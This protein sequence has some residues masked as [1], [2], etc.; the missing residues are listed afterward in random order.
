MVVAR[1][2]NDTSRLVDRAS[3]QGLRVAFTYTQLIGA[4]TGDS[5]A[6]NRAFSA[7]SVHTNYLTVHWRSVLVYVVP[8]ICDK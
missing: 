7:N 8:V 2:S 4:N 3:R 6:K 1:I 5:S